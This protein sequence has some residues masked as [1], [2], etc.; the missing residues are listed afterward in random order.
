[1]SLKTLSTLSTLDSNNS[2]SG[3]LDMFILFIF[4]RL[5]FFFTF[6]AMSPTEVYLS[7]AFAS[8][9]NLFIYLFFLL[10]SSNLFLLIVSKPVGLSVLNS[11]Y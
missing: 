11:P 1:M 2:K 6:S 7:L 10:K 5:N 4:L 3:K 9:I 8:E